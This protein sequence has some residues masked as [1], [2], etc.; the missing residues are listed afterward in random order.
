M[1]TVEDITLKELFVKLVVIDVSEKV[2]SNPDYL[3]QMSDIF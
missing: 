3:L 2:A 1:R